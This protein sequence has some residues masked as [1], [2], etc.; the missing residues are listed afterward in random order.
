MLQK[1]N[2]A[3]R[4][5]FSSGIYPRGGLSTQ[6]GGGGGGG[7]ESIESLSQSTLR[8]AAGDIFYIAPFVR[9]IFTCRIMSKHFIARRQLPQEC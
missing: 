2:P 1:V 3:G 9:G 6:R 5:L 7:G 8:G 4:A